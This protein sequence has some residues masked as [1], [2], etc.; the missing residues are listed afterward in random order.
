MELN[1]L[2]GIGVDIADIARFKSHADALPGGPAA[3]Y[4]TDTELAEAQS[5]TA[6]AEY[7]ASRFAAKEAVMK[8]LGQGMDGLS[9]KEIAISSDEDGRPEVRLTGKA[10]SRLAELGGFGVLLSIS[11][12]KEQAVAMAAAVSPCSK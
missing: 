5:K 11:H 1:N 4:L 10:A 12:G 6:K 9:F 3:R 2:I 8:S 7:L